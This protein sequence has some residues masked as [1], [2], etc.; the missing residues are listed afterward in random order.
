MVIRIQA[1]YNIYKIHKDITIIFNFFNPSLKNIVI[2]RYYLIWFLFD[3]Y[4]KM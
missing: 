4:V 3:H 1:S 2:P